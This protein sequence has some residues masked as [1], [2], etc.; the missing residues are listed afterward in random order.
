VR[1]GLRAAVTSGTAAALADLPAAVGAK[2]GTAQDGGLPEDEYDI[3]TTAAAPVDDPGI[4]VTAWV[5]APGGRNA[6]NVVH[7]TLADYLG[8]R[9]EVLATGPVQGP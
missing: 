7:D 6:S 2:T 3:W 8:Q 5:Q 9:D 1:A 4:V